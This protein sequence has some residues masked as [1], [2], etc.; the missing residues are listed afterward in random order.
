MITVLWIPQID[1]VPNK[2]F[3]SLRDTTLQFSEPL[4]TKIG[5]FVRA[6]SKDVASNTE[7]TIRKIS[8]WE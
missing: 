7:K 3:E 8:Q 5:T 6:F 4:D 2:D 1:F